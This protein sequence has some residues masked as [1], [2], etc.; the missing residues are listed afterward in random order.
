MPGSD[1]DR[2]GVLALGFLL[3]GFGAGRQSSIAQRHPEVFFWPSGLVESWGAKAK[4]PHI[5]SGKEWLFGL[6]AF[7]G[8]AKKPPSP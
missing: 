6:A 3:H 1:S 2:P 5:S 4:K 8:K 7:G